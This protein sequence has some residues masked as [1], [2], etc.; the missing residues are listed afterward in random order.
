MGQITVDGVTYTSDAPASAPSKPRAAS[1]FAILVDGKVATRE[2]RWPAELQA[3]AD[4][5]EAGSAQRVVR[6]AAA[7][8]ATPRYSCDNKSRTMRL[9]DEERAVGHG[10]ANPK[11][12]GEPCP[13]SV[14]CTGKVL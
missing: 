10:F 2:A 9:G 13:S 14:P 11:K 1:P 8:L 7:W 12:S 3:Y 4:Q 6:D 5:A